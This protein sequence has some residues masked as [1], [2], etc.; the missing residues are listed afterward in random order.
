MKSPA[1]KQHDP[2]D[3]PFADLCGDYD[4]AHQ[5]VSPLE[6]GSG[7]I[8]GVKDDATSA[9]AAAAAGKQPQ[10]KESDKETAAHDDSSR[11]EEDEDAPKEH[12]E[13]A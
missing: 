4:A 10:E 1:M 7:A 13:E 3:D 6:F 12:K 11:N 5:M 9:A 2:N 8:G